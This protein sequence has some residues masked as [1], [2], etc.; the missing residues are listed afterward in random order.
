MAS[1]PDYR[2]V[3][4]TVDDNLADLASG[5]TRIGVDTEFM[6]ERTY[7]AE[8]SL[9]QI[10]TPGGIVCAD[11]LGSKPGGPPV[12][13]A[14][15]EALMQPEWVLH[16]A[17][18]DIEVVF[19]T[20]G[21]MPRAV[22]DTQ[23][24]AAL[25]GFQPQLGYGGLVSELFGVSLDKSHTRADWSKRP[26]ADALLKYAAEDVQYLLPAHDMLVDRLRQAGRLE[27]AIEDSLAL[28]TPELYETDPTLA[29]HRLKGAR[30]L[31]GRARAAATELAAWRETEALRSNRPR[32]WI[33]RDQQLLEIAV[34]RPR[35]QAE[36]AGIEGLSE[37]TVRRAGEELLAILERATHD[38]TGYAPPPRP[39]QRQKET[40][41]RMQ[42]RVASLAGDLGLAAEI[43]APKK[44]LFAAL[45][46]DRHSRVFSGWRRP[47]V[48]DALL[49]LLEDG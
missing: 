8:L 5:A 3:D 18:Q 13:A 10:A 45:C 46:G 17:R 22:F 19:Q 12:P 44:E 49:E 33:M 11:P 34:R 15:W 7:F 37:K 21:R 42:K 36:L 16:S 35:T 41:D 26:L 47:L 9:L 40:L 23:I 24:A 38:A 28:L 27:W 4:L 25:L 20:A 43:V 48:G 30:S 2:L 32:Q 31:S 6:R 14:F 29:I 1:L 39:D